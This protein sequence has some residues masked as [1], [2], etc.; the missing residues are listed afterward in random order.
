MKRIREISGTETI[1]NPHRGFRPFSYSAS[2]RAAPMFDISHHKQV[3]EFHLERSV[4]S[5]KDAFCFC[6]KEMLRN[7]Y[8][9]LIQEDIRALLHGEG[10]VVDTTIRDDGVFSAFVYET[11]LHAVSAPV[12]RSWVHH[13]IDLGSQVRTLTNTVATLVRARRSTSHG[14]EFGFV[15]ELHIVDDTATT[16]IIKTPLSSCVLESHCPTRY[17]PFLPNGEVYGE[18]APPQ[19]VL[20]TCTQHMYCT[21]PD[22]TQIQR[23]NLAKKVA[24]ECT[25]IAFMYRKQF[26]EDIEQQEQLEQGG[27][28]NPITPV[29]LL[30]PARHQH[31]SLTFQSAHH[32]MHIH[33]YNKLIALYQSEH[34]DVD[35]E[36][37]QVMLYCIVSMLTRY[38]PL[39]ETKPDPWQ[40]TIPPCAMS[41]LVEQMGVDFDCFACPLTTQFPRYCSPF[42]DTDESFGSLGSFFAFEAT[43][44]S[45][46]AVPPNVSVIVRSTI[47]RIVKMLERSTAP[48]SFVLVLKSKHRG[49]QLEGAEVY[50]FITYD[51]V[52]QGGEEMISNMSDEPTPPGRVI[53]FQNAEG[54]DKWPAASA[55]EAMI[56]IWYHS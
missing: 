30:Q 44:G 38:C 51:K 54:R 2:I 39:F 24:V 15:G 7:K 16:M 43:S 6:H 47:Q 40:P 14:D 55:I 56:E 9:V 27:T 5:V 52:I 34:G 53:A 36:S 22:L 48:M 13:V 21:R 46:V 49:L 41:V 10:V 45:F 1:H 50:S 3:Q 28:P 25:V 23:D 37:H 18:D 20:D 26:Y 35:S 31:V 8:A 4:G 11:I 12:H 19:S 17:D 29:S 33:H 42:L 32:T